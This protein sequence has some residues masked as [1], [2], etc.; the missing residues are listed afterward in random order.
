[1]SAAP[2]VKAALFAML[3]TAYAAEAVRVTY[4]HPGRPDD[5]DIVAAMDVWGEQEWAAMRAGGATR[6][7]SLLLSVALS[8][9]VGGGPEAQQPATERAYALLAILETALRADPTLGGT[10][11]SAGLLSHEMVEATSPEVLT[12]GRVTDISAIV[13]AVT[14]I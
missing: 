13:R 14:R 12:R 2:A 4:G 1:M 6:E 3:N 9:Y 8:C 10:V 7:E 11:R 5:A